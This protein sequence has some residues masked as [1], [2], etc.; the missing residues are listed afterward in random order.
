MQDES[1]QYYE[2]HAAIVISQSNK[3]KTVKNNIIWIVL[4]YQGE[5]D[6]KAKEQVLTHRL[7]SIHNGRIGHGTH[8]YLYREFLEDLKKFDLHQTALIWEP[9]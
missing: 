7:V 8:Y 3:A 4:E 2:L 1:K 5:Y 9:I 6:K